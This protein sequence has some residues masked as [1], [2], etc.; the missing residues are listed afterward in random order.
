MQKL[1]EYITDERIIYY[2]CRIRAK[3]A[4][5]RSKKHLVHLLSSNENYNYH[6]NTVKQ[7]EKIDDDLNLLNG[8][9]PSRRK[10]KK[11]TKAKRYQKNNQRINSVDYNVNSLLLTIDFYRKNHPDNHF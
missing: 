5:Q 3:H 9:L 6:L 8:M 1:D 11:L 10:W 7:K 4:K 2:L